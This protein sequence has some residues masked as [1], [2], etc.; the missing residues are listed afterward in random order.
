MSV[1]LR[2]N[3]LHPQLHTQPPFPCPPLP[4]LNPHLPPL[5]KTC[6]FS[7]ELDIGSSPTPSPAP[8]PSLKSLKSE[9]VS[10]AFSNGTLQLPP[11]RYHLSQQQLLQI[12]LTH[13]KPYGMT[14]LEDDQKQPFI[15]PMSAASYPAII[16]NL[17]PPL[18]AMRAYPTT[19]EA[20]LPAVEKSNEFPPAKNPQ[21]AA[22]AAV[23]MEIQAPRKRGRKSKQDVL[24]NRVAL[25]EKEKRANHM[26]AEQ[27]RRALVRSSLHELSVLV[28]MKPPIE[29][30][31]VSC[32]TA[33]GSSRVEILEGGKQF[34]EELVRRNA[35]L[36]KQLEQLEQRKAGHS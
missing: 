8:S 21:T 7:P 23:V 26:V 24:L 30:D 28:G 22:A 34:L 16:P 25:T 18:L 9:H 13:H 5:N 1:Q 36:R 27:R 12:P 33:D 6:G 19:P 15:I 4:H 31:G 2:Q 11:L 20:V 14:S 32:G 3:L 29:G 17:L 35:E 10:T